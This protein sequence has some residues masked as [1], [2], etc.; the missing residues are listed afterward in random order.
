MRIDHPMVRAAQRGARRGV[1]VAG[2]RVVCLQASDDRAALA[3]DDR[4]APTAGHVH[5]D[6]GE[7]ALGGA[8]ACPVP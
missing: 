6:L 1:V 4:L 7:A 5:D 2:L 3:S 8:V